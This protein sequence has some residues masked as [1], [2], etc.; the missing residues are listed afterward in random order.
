MINYDY[1]ETSIGLMEIVCEDDFLIGLKMV[2]E[3]NH[4]VNE[5]KISKNKISKKVKSQILE[6]LNGS[7]KIFTIPIKL[8]GTD[9]QKKVYEETL[10]IPYG[11]TKTYGEIANSIGNPKSM[12]AVGMAL[13]KNPIW[14]IMPCHRVIGKNNKLTGYAGGIDKKLSLL[15]LENPKIEIK[16]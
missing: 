16:E 14:I 8:N 4:I 15:K 5:N 3:K 13:G 2:L 12:R 6:Y 10:K 1:L 7:R 11:S 9:F